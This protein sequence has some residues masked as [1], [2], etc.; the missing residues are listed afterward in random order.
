[1][2]QVYTNRFIQIQYSNFVFTVNVAINLPIF[3]LSTVS[4]YSEQ[5]AFTSLLPY[6]EIINMLDLIVL[7]KPPSY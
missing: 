3:K 5:P 6:N 2:T 4:S 1:M 7:E